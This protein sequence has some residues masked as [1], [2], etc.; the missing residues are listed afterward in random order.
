[1]VVAQER[2]D[3]YSLPE[4]ASRVNRRPKRNWLPSKGKYTLT[5]LVLLVFCTGMLIAFYYTQ[6]IISGY[7]IYSLNNQLAT[8][9]QETVSLSEEVDRL[10]SLDRIEYLATSKLKMVKPGSRDVVVVKADLAGESGAGRPA[11]AM[12]GTGGAKVQ[13]QQALARQNTGKSK[14]IQAFANLMGI[15]GS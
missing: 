2:Y 12:A 1:V 14:V 7:K 6:V 4:E 11:V 8:L 3:H 13:Q 10:N 15:K 9:R 5:F